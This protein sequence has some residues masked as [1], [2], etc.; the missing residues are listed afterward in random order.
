MEEFHQS[1]DI[2]HSS[3]DAQFR[4]GDKKHDPMSSLACYT[5]DSLM[6]LVCMPIAIKE[7]MFSQFVNGSSEIVYF[8]MREFPLCS[9]AIRFLYGLGMCFLFY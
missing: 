1:G 7:I 2:Y 9:L 8:H 6:N 5:M 3:E 4:L